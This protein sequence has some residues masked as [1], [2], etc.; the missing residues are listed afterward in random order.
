MLCVR[1]GRDRTHATSSRGA[2]YTLADY[3]METEPSVLSDTVNPS[4]CTP[5][6]SP[7]LPHPLSLPP[8]RLSG[9]SVI[10]AIKVSGWVGGLYG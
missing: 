1:V 9:E 5:T 3:A 10:G 4:F 2:G 7:S 6:F 8:V